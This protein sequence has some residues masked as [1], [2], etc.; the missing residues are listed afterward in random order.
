MD[1]RKILPI[2]I[3]VVLIILLHYTGILRP[4]ENYL[5]KFL[6][7]VEKYVFYAG[8]KI[9]SYYVEKRID[10]EDVV[11]VNKILEEDNRKLLAEN[12]K[13]KI[14]ADENEIL[15]QQLKFYSKFQYH[16]VLA[17]IISKGEGLTTGQVIALDKG[18]EDG[19]KEEQ[20]IVAGEGQIVG[21]IFKVKDGLSYGRLITDERSLIAATIS[22]KPAIDGLTKGELGLT[23]KMDF[24]PQKIEEEVNINDIVITSGLEPTIPMG[25]IIGK[26]QEITKESNDLFQTAVIDPLVNLNALSVV[27]VIIY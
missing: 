19:I 22:G 26:I 1:K 15:R 8:N 3:A 14:L 11:A 4:I 12:V 18:A 20:A 6:S 23:V 27:S 17:N 25:L 5:V 7:P 2:I 10:K 24:V 13:L 21:K 16:K 9:K